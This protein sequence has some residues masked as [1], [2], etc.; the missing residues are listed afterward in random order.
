MSET[1]GD[2][3]EV[4]QWIT[5]GSLSKYLKKFKVLMADVMSQKDKASKLYTL[6]LG[7]LDLLSE[8]D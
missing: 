7:I 3:K 4:M 8:E 2:L 5:T 6:G 1:M